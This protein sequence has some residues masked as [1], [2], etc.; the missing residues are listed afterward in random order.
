M[1][2]DSAVR[3][4]ETTELM[5][6]CGE[7]GLGPGPGEPRIKMAMSDV[8]CDACCDARIRFVGAHARRNVD[9]DENLRIRRCSSRTLRYGSVRV[10]GVRLC[11][12]M[13]CEAKEGNEQRER[14]GCV[15]TG[16]GE[17]RRG[18]F[19]LRRR[20]CETRVRVDTWEMEIARRKE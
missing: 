14:G 12:L 3:V 8:A 2:V 20:V 17:E 11:E 1:G 9:V 4:T 18:R 10:C 7:R 5:N 6:G 16:A 19:F 13:R 15:C